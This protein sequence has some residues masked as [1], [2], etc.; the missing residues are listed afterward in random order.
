MKVNVKNI[1]SEV[2]VFHEEESGPALDLETEIVKFK[3]PLK[4]TACIY[5]VTNA[6]TADIKLE[7]VMQNV[8]TRCL[9][10]FEDRFEK[11]SRLYYALDSKMAVIDLGPDIREEIILDYPV[12]QLCRR[13][14]KGL[15]AKCGR[16]L[17]EE[18]CSCSN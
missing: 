6:I 17:N 10:E 1:S 11:E 14:C 2:R 18:K 16:N 5:R 13:D 7:A 9:H 12:V 8:C 15:C 4:I 3:G